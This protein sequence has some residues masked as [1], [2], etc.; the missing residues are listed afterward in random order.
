MLLGLEEACI[1][2]RAPTDWDPAMQG[3]LAQVLRPDCHE[4]G[5]CH[6][7]SGWR[8]SISQSKRRLESTEV[9][10]NPLHLRTILNRARLSY[11]NVLKS[12]SSASRIPTTVQL[13]ACSIHGF[14]ITTQSPARRL[15]AILEIVS[16]SMLQ[17]SP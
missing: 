9:L 13:W 6:S 5:L 12:Y 17:S 3:H 10:P 2:P 16:F 15:V 14:E 7:F 8:P 1:C 4:I 11:G